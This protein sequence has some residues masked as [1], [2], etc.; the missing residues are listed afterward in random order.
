M[1]RDEE[2]TKSLWVRTAGTSDITVVAYYRSPDQEDQADA[3]FTIPDPQGGT[4][5][6]PIPVGERAQQG[7]SNPGGSCNALMVMS[8][9]SDRGAKEERS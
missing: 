7:I 5:T 1:G 9:F 3:T 2:Q 4:S 6:T 8:V